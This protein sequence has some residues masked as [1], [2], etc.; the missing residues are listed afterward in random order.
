MFNFK[1]NRPKF[2]SLVTPKLVDEALNA[3]SDDVLPARSTFRYCI[4]QIADGDSE[5]M[6]D[7]VETVLSLSQERFVS[8]TECIVAS[9]VMLSF[10][11]E[12]SAPNEISQCDLVTNE[13]ITRLKDRC[14]IV[15]GRLHAH[16]GMIS[17]KHSWFGI[18]CPDI[19]RIFKILFS[20]P[21]GSCTTADVPCVVRD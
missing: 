5:V 1:K 2:K 18:L 16:F 10:P 17:N 8:S 7:D 11:R 6:R 12:T 13:V 20:T 4:I 9:I 19:E 15:T 14:R 3:K 21:F